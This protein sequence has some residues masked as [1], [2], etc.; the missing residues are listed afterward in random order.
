MSLMF[1]NS[2]KQNKKQQHDPD[3]Y[4]HNHRNRC[5]GWV[6][7]PSISLA[8]TTT[9]AP[10]NDNNV[11]TKLQNNNNTVVTTRSSSSVPQI[12]RLENRQPKQSYG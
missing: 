7:K 11:R 12:T 9:K 10:D 5:R 3:F 1:C 4:S 6:V 8:T 2:N